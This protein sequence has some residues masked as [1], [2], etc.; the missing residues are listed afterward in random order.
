MSKIPTILPQS[1]NLQRCST[2]TPLT[3]GSLVSLIP[4]AQLFFGSLCIE[5]HQAWFAEKTYCLFLQLAVGSTGWTWCV[6]WCYETLLQHVPRIRMPRKCCAAQV[7]LFDHFVGGAISAIA[8]WRW[9]KNQL[10]KL[11]HSDCKRCRL[12]LP[13][14]VCWQSIIL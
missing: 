6:T 7:A 8:N 2:T 10:R 14:I 1:C 9:D 4:F 11:R 12:P 5:R 3:A 13:S